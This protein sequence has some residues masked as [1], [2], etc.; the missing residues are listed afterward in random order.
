MNTATA[1]VRGKA[2]MNLLVATVNAALERGLISLDCTPFESDCFEFELAGLP[3]KACV[4]DAGF[5]EIKIGAIVAPT[6]LGKRC[7]GSA[8]F[9]ERKRFGAAITGAWLERR[10]GKYLQT[11]VNYH[12]AKDVTKALAEL[13]VV[14]NGFG[15]K[16]SPGGYDFFDEC[17]RLFGKPIRKTV[18]LVYDPSRLTAE[19]S[20]RSR[21]EPLLITPAGFVSDASTA[22]AAWD[23]ETK[24]TTLNRQV[25]SAMAWLRLCGQSKGINRGSTS[26]SLKHE[27]EKWARAQ[28]H[29]N[30]GYVANGCLL[31]AACLLGFKVWRASERPDFPNGWINIDKQ[32]P[33][34]SGN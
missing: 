1:S 15:T 24:S 11:G 3:V 29:A 25:E 6:A 20:L 4:H 16:P 30:G 12:G 27:A 18:E 8:I 7:A 34:V 22:A 17:D 21:F 5:D 28:G 10:T 9:G 31:M 26:Y 32:R 23:R 19:R 33:G 13:I 14:P 2:R